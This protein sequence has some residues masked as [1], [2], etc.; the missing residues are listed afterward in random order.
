MG[1]GG[2]PRLYYCWAAGRAPSSGLP[3][4]SVSGLGPG[5]VGVLGGLVGEHR[6][7]H[8]GDVAAAAGVGEA[9]LDQGQEALGAEVAQGRPRGAQRGEEDL[10]RRQE[11]RWPGLGAG[12]RVP[13]PLP[14]PR[15]APTS[16]TASGSCATSRYICSQWRR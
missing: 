15:R 11:A 3:G 14:E 10:R 9:Q 1:D 13:R 12:T 4:F 6:A 2:G 16:V 7:V 5:A 8:G